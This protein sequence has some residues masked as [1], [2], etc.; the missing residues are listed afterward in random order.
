MSSTVRS[1]M[2]RMGA[3]RTALVALLVVSGMAVAPAVAQAHHVDDVS[4][5]DFYHVGDDA[6]GN[7]MGSAKVVR[8]DDDTTS[9]QV[10]VHGL[11]PGATYSVHLH[12]GACADRGPHY[13]HNPDGPDR[14][15]NE[16]W[17]SS[18]G[19]DPAAGVTAN[20]EGNASGSGMAPWR[21]RG[22]A[23]SVFIHSPA[24]DHPAIGCA[25]LN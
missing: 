11:K 16:L 23:R 10:H 3:S 22:E 2:D 21:A 8:F 15:P 5:G 6:P 25:D 12:F 14:P 7:L 13:R 18:D 24:K 20:D 17:A 1:W 19:D 9:L 4:Q